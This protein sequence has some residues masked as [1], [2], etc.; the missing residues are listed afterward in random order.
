MRI[1]V[2]SMDIEDRIQRYIDEN[3]IEIYIHYDDQLTQKQVDMILE[4]NAEEARW[5]IEDWANMNSYPGE[6]DTYIEDLCKE[7]ECEE[8]DYEKY[9]ENGGYSPAYQLDD[10]GWRQM[11]RNTNV[12]VVAIVPEAE[13]NFNN[14]AYGEP[15]HYSDVKESLKLLGVNPQVFRDIKEGEGLK[16]WFPD[17]PQRVPAVDAKELWDN[18][19]VLY[20]GMLHFCLGDLE[21][22]A[23]VLSSESKNITFKEGTNLVMYD[24]FNGAGVTEAELIRDV[25]IPRDK[26]EFHNDTDNVYGVQSC[27]GFTQSYW[28]DGGI[29]NEK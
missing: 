5:D 14:M 15:V 2:I 11:L 19:C 20:N 29:Q 4:G 6:L 22:I 24:R 21:N 25:T 9:I 13:W 1:K 18:M 10:H 26:V 28:N 23:E 7:L 27:Y 3:P 16:G 12:N 17:L 8:S